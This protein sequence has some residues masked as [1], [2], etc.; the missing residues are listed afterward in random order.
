VNLYKRQAGI[1]VMRVE[2]AGAL[3]A[4][5][6]A[7]AI[8]QKLADAHPDDE[9]DQMLLASSHG[10]HAQAMQG[11][12]KMDDFMVESEKAAT[13]L[14]RILARNPAQREAQIYL[15]SHYSQLGDRYL[16]RDTTPETA[17]LAYD[18]FSQGVALLERASAG[19]PDDA[20]LA[21]RV[22]AMS[23]DVG[24]ALL[25]L[26][27]P[28]EARAQHVKALAIWDRLSG[29]DPANARY[30]F[31]RAHCLGQLGAALID[32]GGTADIAEASQRLQ[33]AVDLFDGLPAGAQQDTY[34]R[35]THGANLYHLGQA[36]QAQGDKRAAKQRYE[37]SLALLD[38]MEK[39]FGNAPGNVSAQDLRTAIER[40]ASAR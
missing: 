4:A 33:S 13:Q 3:A 7:V 14:R 35:Y 24:R 6:K 1:L 29:A 36:L 34:P 28:A 5:S 12:G 21:A 8:A 16:E 2:S 19:K 11:A 20:L 23:D 27:R 26:H 32:I 31:E 10:Q 37:Q 18:A 40:M 9:A 39:H 38:D 25:R 15:S 30:R 17:K 22:A